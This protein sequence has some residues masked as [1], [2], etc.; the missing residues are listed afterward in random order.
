M[1]GPVITAEKVAFAGASQHTNHTGELSGPI[2]SLHFLSLLGP[3]LRAFSV[4]PDTQ[5][6]C[7]WI[8]AV[9]D[10]CPL[11]SNIGCVML[12]VN[13]HQRNRPV[14]CRSAVVR[15]LSRCVCSLSL[16]FLRSFSDALGVL[17]QQ[18]TLP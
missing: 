2:E 18:K 3:V 7:V 13:T 17:D 6:M 9:T 14:P 15:T 1:F 4:T 10:H 8:R 11:G 16:S 5:L 12:V